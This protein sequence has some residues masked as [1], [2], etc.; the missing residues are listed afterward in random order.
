MDDIKNLVKIANQ[1][2]QALLK[3]RNYR[4]LELLNQFG[5]ASDKLHEIVAESKKLALSL[6]HNWFTAAD[7]CCGSID[8]LTSDITYY[9][10]RVKQF[11][12]KPREE[13]PTLSALVEDLKQLEQ[14]FGKIEFD[15]A[16][17]TISLITKPITL[18]DVYLGPFK[19]QLELKKLSELYKD[20]PYYCIALDPHP[21]ATN[22][23]VTHPHVSNDK[24]CEGE[25]CAAIRT[26]LEQGR[27][28]DFFTLV[29]S[30]LNTYSPDSPYVSLYDW[31]G[32]PCYDCGYVMDRDNSYYCSF[33]DRTFCEECSTYC[34]NCE[35]TLCRGCAGKCEICEEPLCSNCAHKCAECGIY[36]CES[37]LEDGICQ[38]CIQ[39]SEDENEQS[40]N[41]TT[42][43]NEK[44][45]TNQSAANTPEIK[46]AS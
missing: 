31:D 18:D 11:A 34:R 8:R 12:E 38:N 17:T 20:S 10:S 9:I 7:Y 23:E 4:Y 14:E 25:G 6:S 32:E 40:G 26:A 1:V 42:G 24:L 21:A 36:C 3:L 37:C 41:Q 19:I 15:K 39:E 28:C 22:E 27:L 5:S 46:L 13:I 45:N 33:C 2:Q 29:K 44:S 35:E 30:I 43:T 16:A